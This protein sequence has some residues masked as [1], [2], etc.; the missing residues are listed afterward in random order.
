MTRSRKEQHG[1]T[2]KQS[3]EWQKL[4]RL[5]EA[6]FEAILA[7]PDRRAKAAAIAAVK[8]EKVGGQG[9]VADPAHALLRDLRALA[10]HFGRPPPS[11]ATLDVEEREALRALCS[12]V[13]PF[14][15]ALGE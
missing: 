13:V 11:F 1:I 9:R 10:S 14:L 5:S 2:R 15:Q 4:A 3:H 7:I 6:E 8:R 12:A